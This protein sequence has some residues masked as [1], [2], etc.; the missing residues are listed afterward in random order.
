[1]PVDDLLRFIYAPLPFSQ[2][3]LFGGLGLIGVVVIWYAS[4]YLWTLPPQRLRRIPLLRNMHAALVRRRFGRSIRHT[5]GLYRQGAMTSAQACAALSRTLRS[6]LYV[7]TG[8]R[9]QYLHVSE[10]SHGRLTT[11]VPLLVALG[12]AQFNTSTQIDIVAL[13]DSAREFVR[14]WS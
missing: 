10:M 12:D 14:T 5:C 9:A 4:L 1:M 8:A 7:T 2:A 3:W 6:F 11:A 13:G